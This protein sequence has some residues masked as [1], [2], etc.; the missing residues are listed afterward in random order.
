MGKTTLRNNSG[1]NVQVKEGNA[2]IFRILQVLEDGKSMTIRADSTAT[3]REYVLILLPDNKEL[4]PLTSDDIQE[5]DAIEI[6]K[7]NGV[8]DWREF[9]GGAEKKSLFGVV[10]GWFSPKSGAKADA[11]ADPE[12]DAKADSK[13]DANVEANAESSK[14]TTATE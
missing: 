7:D 10:L 5:L 9:R 11:K 14:S 6:F 8:Y 1:S 13:A 2:N 4:R 12:A 3:Y